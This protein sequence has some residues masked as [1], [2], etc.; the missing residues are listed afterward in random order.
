MDSEPVA[1][2]LGESSLSSHLFRH[3]SEIAVESKG[4]YLQGS[5]RLPTTPRPLFLRLSLVPANIDAERN[6]FHLHP[7]LLHINT[8]INKRLRKPQVR[9]RN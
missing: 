4:G 6:L 3:V 1:V 5:I 8:R 7:N 9:R 2:V